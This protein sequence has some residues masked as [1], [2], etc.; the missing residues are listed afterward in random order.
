MSQRQQLERIMVIDHSIRDGEYPNAD[1]LAN[2]LEV[3][4]RVIFNDREFMI[5]RL[6]APIE[7]DRERGGWY[8]TNKTWVLPGMIVTEGELLAFFL[9]VEISK[10]FLGSSL[11]SPLRS[12]VEKISKGVKGPVTVDLDTLHLHYTFS[13]PALVMSNEK[14]LL[15]LQHAITHQH[16]IW[17]RYFTAGRLEFT[18]RK[19]MPYHMHNYRGDWFLIG[20]DTLRTD[21]R[22]FLVGRIEKWKV[23]PEKFERDE[24][25]DASEW[26]G[27]AFQLFGGGEV[28]DVSIWFSPQKAQFIRERLWH[29]S[30][31]IDENSDG[32]LVLHMKTAGLL[33]V[34][35]WV[36]NF[37]GGAEVLAPESLRQEC[38]TE[39][40]QMQQVYLSKDQEKDNL[41]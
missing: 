13:S 31:R 16:C 12:A 17:M 33:E 20:F 23:L 41:S 25:F 15:D 1:R 32:S 7:Y 10:R 2:M 28:E 36:L 35:Y 18:E 27:R 38:I 37:G 26:M 21:F 8:Y 29:A 4:R 40:K 14:I 24:T 9:S 34:K 39:I 30:Q 22:I 19:V 6:G 3:S 11:E 5:N